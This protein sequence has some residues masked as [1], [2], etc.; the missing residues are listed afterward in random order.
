MKTLN[1]NAIK[2]VLLLTACWMVWQ[3]LHAAEAP[4]VISAPTL[5]S[6]K[7]SGSMQTA[8]VAGGCF[9]G[10]QGVF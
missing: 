7:A 3:P 9:W 8:V 2:Y 1:R 6:K 5:D 10:V 4:T